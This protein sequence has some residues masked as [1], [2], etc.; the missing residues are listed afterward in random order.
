[1]QTFEAPF[2]RGNCPIY[3]WGPDNRTAPVILYFPDAFGPRLA[4]FDVAAE[5]AQEGWRVLMLDQFYEHIPYE[6]LTPNAFN[7]PGPNR[8]RVMQM[9][10]SITMEKIDAD[11]QAMIDLAA[12]RSDP[13]VK[14]AAI[15]YCMGGRYC[16][17]AV[18]R[19]DRVVFA[20]AF[21]AAHIAPAAGDGP[22]QR[23]AQ[24]SGRIYIGVSGIDPMY[25]HE[26]HGRVASLLREADTDHAIETYRGVGHGFVFPDLA[27]YDRMAAD[28]HMRRIKENLTE[29]FAG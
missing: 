13:G 14:F 5:L 16:L 12:S 24:A 6:P 28:K 11:T 25:G 18:C 29:L 17:S 23:F 4:S 10:G 9:F 22:H 26:E 21:H 8:D 1:M 15:G 20:G 7:E 2:P 3:A 19:D 27:V